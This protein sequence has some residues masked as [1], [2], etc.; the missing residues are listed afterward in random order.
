VG[1]P[2][3][4][5]HELVGG[6]ATAAVLELPSGG[7][8]LGTDEHSA[9][10]AVRLFGEQPARVRVFANGP[11]AE[12][13][14]LR[15]VAIGARVT[16]MTDQV[17]R[18]APLVQAMPRSVPGGPPLTVL[19]TSGRAPAGA[20]AAAPS[21]VIQSTQAGAAVSLGEQGRWQTVLVASPADS[22]T[23]VSLSDLREHHLL[24]TERLPPFAVQ[25]IREAFGLPY[26]RAV[27]LSQLSEGRVAVVAPG[28]L[29]LVDLTLSSR[30]R[31]LLAA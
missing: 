16:V 6:R 30:E 11:L 15:A 7:M 9:P 8:V 19:P 14:G 23:P 10:L 3:L 18:W 1:L 5:A 27:W 12:V 25:R 2:E 4:P 22:L 26:D 17:A 21:L 13:L 24:I 29:A 28:R 20:T 31:A